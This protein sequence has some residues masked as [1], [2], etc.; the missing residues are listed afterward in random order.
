MR[1]EVGG[2]RAISCVSCLP[3]SPPYSLS[4]KDVDREVGL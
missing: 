2:G 1:D 3:V 4:V